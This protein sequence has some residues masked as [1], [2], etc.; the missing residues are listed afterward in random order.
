MSIN[1]KCINKFQCTR[2]MEYHVV[3]KKTVSYN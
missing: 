2:T 1:S 3:M